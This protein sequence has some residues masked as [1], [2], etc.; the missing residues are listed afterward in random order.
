MTIRRKEDPE[1][2][3]SGHGETVREYFGK[4]VGP[5]GVRH[6]LARIAIA[7]GKASLR[8]FHPAAEESYFVLSGTARMVVD[9]EESRL[10]PGD[11]VFIAPKREHQIINDGGE[12][13]VFVAVCVPPWT[14]ECSEFTE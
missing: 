8:H 7:P 1:A 5:A 10:G 14:P 2:L 4:A 12:D 6:S 9:G 13:L 11:G 3:A